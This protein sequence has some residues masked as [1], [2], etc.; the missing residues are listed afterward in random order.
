MNRMLFRTGRLT[1]ASLLA[2]AAGATADDVAI[3][4][5]TS[6]LAVD[7]YFTLAEAYGFPG[8]ILV[9]RGGE[10]VLRKGYGLTDKKKGIYNSANTAFGIASLDKQ[11]TAT[12]I[13]ILEKKGSLSVFDPISWHLPDVPPDKS[14]V[15]IH[16]LLSHSS[17]IGD[18][19]RDSFPDLDFVAY[20][21]AILSKPLESK[22]GERFAYTNCGYDLLVRIVE[23]ASRNRY[24]QFLKDNLFRPVG[25]KQTGYRL[26]D[27]PAERIG[28]YEDNPHWNPD[29]PGTKND[30]V[31]L[32]FRCARRSKTLVSGAQR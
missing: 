11:F 3:V 10:V 15:T 31:N 32:F 28:Q 16:H 21:R 23:I 14:D 9:A 7:E 6:G 18:Y 29:F 17:G 5:G 13:L 20:L 8:A 30:P 25:L 1:L 4:R 27:W 26:V 19:Y 12:A 24:E 22:P 2:L